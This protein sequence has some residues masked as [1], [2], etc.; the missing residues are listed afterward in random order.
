MNGKQRKAINARDGALQALIRYE[1][2]QAYLN[3]LLPSLTAHLPAA[4]IGLA[5]QLAAGVVGRLNTLDWLLSQ[6]SKH[7]LNT[8]TPSIRNLLRLGLYQLLYLDRIPAYAAINETVKLAR[9]YGH[10]GTAGLVN[11]LLRRINREKA[12]LPW[13]DRQAEPLLSMSLRCS[14]PLWLAERAIMR[15]GQEEAQIWASSVNSRPPLTLRPNCMRTDPAELVEALEKEEITARVSPLVPWMVR[16]ES[17]GFVP[18]KSSAFKNGYFTV[19]GES[20]A[21]VAPLLNPSSG[22]I[23][24]DLCSAPGGKTTHLA[25][26]MD[27]R[28]TVYAVEP[29]GNRLRLVESAALRLGLQNIVTLNLDGRQLN[30]NLIKA[31]EA[32]LVD[33]P[34]SGLGVI[35]RLPEIKW[36]RQYSDLAGLQQQQ[37]ELLSAAADLLSAGGLLIYSVCSTEPEE[38]SAVVEQFNRKQQ[39]FFPLPL[40]NH[41]PA[42]FHAAENPKGQLTLWPHRQGLDGFFIARW[43]KK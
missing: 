10:R 8:M 25:E 36:R 26:L 41:L 23:V 30:Q 21:L 35:G 7:N 14:L 40:Q 19:Q 13:P 32:I 33:A 3:L 5:R 37:L 24:V 22:G 2:D 6:F 18:A 17:S 4:E 29:H 16:V 27:G 38:T 12:N 11:A 42:G 9:R 20:S 39:V 28:G 43:I 34:C 1:Q 31:P 15:F